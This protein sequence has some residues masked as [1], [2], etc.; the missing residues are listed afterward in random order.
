MWKR[1]GYT[2]IEL[3]VALAVG[4]VVATAIGRV[5]VHTRRVAQHLAQRMELNQTLRSTAA[6]LPVDLR[7]LDTSDPAGSDIVQM[8]DSSLT[9]KAMRG[10]YLTCLPASGGRVSLDTAMLGSRPLDPEFDSLLIL[11]GGLLPGGDRWVHL[12]LRSVTPGRNCPGGR[13]SLDAEVSPAVLNPDSLPPG[14]PLRSF[15]VTEVRRYADGAGVSWLGA[16]RYSKATRWN[17]IQPVAGPLSPAGLRFSYFA[18]DGLP[19][20][21]P[22]RVTRIGLMVAA[23]TPV[24]VWLGGT[25]PRYLVDSL[26]TQVALRNGR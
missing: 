25:E 14:S 17:A 16:R 6:I 12:D 13:P 4:G 11:S 1:Y 8:S 10:F 22:R 19:T 18:R 20:G 5:L 3:L 7:G 2:L 15:E 23:R 9:Y 21:D 24:P 26:A